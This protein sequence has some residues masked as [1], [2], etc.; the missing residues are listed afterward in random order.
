[1][2]VTEVKY[3]RRYNVGQYEHE[4]YTLVTV[5][6]EGDEDSKTVIA[7][8]KEDVAQAHAGESKK[9]GVGEKPAKGKK[10]S[11]AKAKKDSEEEESSVENTEDSP[12]PAKKKKSF[13][14]KAASYDRA[15]EIHKKLFSEQLQAISPGWSKDKEKMSLA[16]KLSRQMHGKE[17][18]DSDGKVINEFYRELKKAMGGKK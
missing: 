9:A 1:M 11:S 3:T 17:M 12:A 7:E 6:E 15:N 13:K 8:L 10:A 14:S 5:L 4:E 18:L 16:N 2:R